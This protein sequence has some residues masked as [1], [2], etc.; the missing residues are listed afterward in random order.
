MAPRPLAAALLALA[1]AAPAALAEGDSQER[2]FQFQLAR[3]REQAARAVTTGDRSVAREA[4]DAFLAAS[5]LRPKD[6]V[7]LAEAG[8]LGLDI[9]DGA[10]AARMLA[11][12]HEIAPT[13]GAFHFLR[14]SLL[15]L[16]GEYADAM[17]EYGAA[18]EGDFKPQQAADRFFECKLGH[19]FLLV[20]GLRFDDA[21]KVLSEAVAM[22]PT[23]PMVPRAYFN[24]ALAYRRLQT[25]KE[26]ERVLRLCIERF[27]SFPLAYGELGD[28]LADLARFDEALALFDR[29]VKVDEA[30]W[31][32]HVLKGVTLTKMGRFEEADAA[33]REYEKRFLPTGEAELQRGVHFQARGQPEKGLERLRR[34]L[35]LDASQIRAH[36]YMSLCF[37][38]LQ[39]EEEAAA[40]MDRWRK[41]EEAL[42]KEHEDKRMN[43]GDR[44]DPEEGPAKGGDGEAPPRGDGKPGDGGHGED[45]R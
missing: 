18:M 12:I 43:L 29:S 3:A 35:A 42:R 27:P 21:L 44:R 25:P 23:H 2:A 22:K 5:R 16:R 34:A 33:F 40:A 26:A 8:L 41:A 9:G 20:E 13:S 39:M 14:G 1:L 4:F 24:M 11:A 37:R 32:G 36:Y 19:G 45:P 7:P 15:Q 10:A 28:M 31:R 17:A 30:Y 6:P 38:D